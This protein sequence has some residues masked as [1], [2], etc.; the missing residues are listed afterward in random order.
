MHNFNKKGYFR[1]T[2]ATMESNPFLKGQQGHCYQIPK[3]GI[4]S[5][6]C[7]YFPSPSKSIRGC[8]KINKKA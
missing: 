7:S 4:S 2:T 3:L 1:K 5:F 8:R 6:S